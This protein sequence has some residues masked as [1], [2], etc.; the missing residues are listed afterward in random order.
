MIR[1]ELESSLVDE[2]TAEY[3]YE[4]TSKDGEYIAEFKGQLR[5]RKVRKR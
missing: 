4:I 2:K 1:K 3:E 5:I